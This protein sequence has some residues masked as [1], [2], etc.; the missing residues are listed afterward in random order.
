M[1]IFF[2]SNYKREISGR[3]KIQRSKRNYDIPNLI[4]LN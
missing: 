1:A 3:V 2:K 4:F